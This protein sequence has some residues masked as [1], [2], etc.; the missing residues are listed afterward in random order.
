MYVPEWKNWLCTFVVL[1]G[2]NSDLNWTLI[3]YFLSNTKCSTAYIFLEIM[4][5]Q[6]HVHRYTCMNA[7]M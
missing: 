4:Y 1:N 6:A 7:P 2:S 5:T 3:Q